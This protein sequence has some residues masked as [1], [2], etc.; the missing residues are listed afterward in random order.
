[1]QK[2]IDQFQQ[3]GDHGK[4]GGQ[5]RPGAPLRIQP[6]WRMLFWYCLI[7]LAFQWFWME[8]ARKFV[9]RTIPYSE[10]K[11]LLADGK[12]E[13][14]TVAEAEIT[15]KI[16]GPAPPL[17]KT[18]IPPEKSSP[19]ASP[20]AL[21]VAEESSSAKSSPAAAPAAKPEVAVKQE[22][23]T[24]SSAETQKTPAKPES[25]LFRTVRVEDPDLVSEMEKAGVTF[26][27]ERPSFLS[28]ILWSWVVP[29]GVIFLL[30]GFLS[31]RMAGMGKSIL[32]FGSSKARLA[33]EKDTSVTFD[34]VAGCEEAKY[35]LKEVVDFL[36]NPGRY[37]ALGAKIPKGVLLVGPPGT[38][39]TLLARAVAGEAKVPF[40]SISGS[41]FVE[42]F[43]GVGAARVR[44]LFEKAK[45]QAP[46]IVFI[47]EL[48]SIGRQRGVHI[49]NV[50]DEREQTLNQMLAAMDGFEA[51]AG[52]V[53]L[54][55]T[56]RPEVLDRA[57]LRPG[58]F[59][60]QVVVDA[61]DL[62]GRVA[63]LRLHQRGKPLAAAADLRKIAQ[64]TPGFS[65]ADLENL[66]NEAALLAARH[67]ATE[68][69]Q[70][71]LQ[72]AVEKVIAGPERRSRRLNEKD[73]RLVAFHEVGHALVAAFS[74]H[75]DA[76]HKISIV[77]RGHAA[78]GY[79][80]QLPEDD[81]YLRSREELRD[82]IKGLLGGRA[83]EEVVFGEITTGAE[84][85]LEHATALARQMV[86]VYG[87]GESV[88]LVH[89]AQKRPQFLPDA[90]GDGAWQRDCSEETARKIDEEVKKILDDAYSDAKR[91]LREHRDMLDRIAN[92]L[93][94]KETLDSKAFKS[95]L[96][97]KSANQ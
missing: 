35:E 2:D 64:E 87:M 82:K 43:V 1:M 59:D 52:V 81:Q 46:C 94:E 92:E 56:N 18:G 55:A 19:P 14:A 93:L 29:I 15:G 22:S 62:D 25:Y 30:W 41:E 70:A 45:A 8:A 74:G 89:C 72:E 20:A 91:I 51:N 53:V 66:M 24:P 86:C 85:D 69:S 77:P 39:K 4:T 13:E 40:F 50:S 78:L 76:V 17:P 71:D 57:L 73:K 6:Q 21:P 10:F 32:S 75:A 48:D 33:A 65:G 97:L 38:G 7:L 95:F 88:G 26:S 96:E 84:N 23:G 49:G 16:R 68:I 67:D 83:A 37:Q 36:R 9:V 34:D 42:M 3:R 5:H 47:D 31:R 54:A 61:P 28:Q 80:L 79:T 12:V 58:R 11:T 60:R 27:G 90:M 63:I 44:D